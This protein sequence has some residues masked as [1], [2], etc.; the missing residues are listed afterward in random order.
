VAR[1]RQERG[2]RPKA[3]PVSVHGVITI[4]GNTRSA[5]LWTVAVAGAVSVTGVAINI[6]TDLKTSVLAWLAVAVA[7]A[8]AGVVTWAGQL[9][10]SG[11]Q[12]HPATIAAGAVGFVLAV[13]LGLLAL[14]PDSI[15]DR[16]NTT[17]A[18]ESGQPATTRTATEEP[19]RTATPGRV[20]Q[21]VESYRLVSS[22]DFCPTS[23]KVDLDTARSGYGG[24]S[25]LGDYIDQCRVEGGLAELVLEQ[26]E[27]HTPKNSQ[28]LYLLEP[29]EAEGQD[30]C[31]AALQKIERLRSRVALG[32]LRPDA[33][34]CIKTD[35]GN[36]AQVTVLEV[37]HGLQSEVTVRFTTWE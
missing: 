28:L 13:I 9:A 11:Q 15:P 31:R 6:A 17:E 30:E 36:I 2:R 16:G 23:D 20:I 26:D 27:L 10:S 25:Q 34:V 21:N 24:Q 3:R 33:H 4:V 7:T 18:M 12:V 32:E 5:W 1:L 8:T 35:Q 14:V 19:N 22:S 37:S 29:N